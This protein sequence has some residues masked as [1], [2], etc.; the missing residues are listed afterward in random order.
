MFS[1]GATFAENCD[2]LDWFEGRR[3]RESRDRSRRI[4]RPS[5]H[6]RPSSPAGGSSRALRGRAFLERA[7]A[8]RAL[9]AAYVS[10]QNSALLYSLLDAQRFE[11]KRVELIR[12]ARPRAGERTGP[13]GM[14]GTI[15]FDSRGRRRKIQGRAARSLSAGD[16]R[17]SQAFAW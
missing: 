3:R 1:L 16:E 15:F 7:Q 2:R 17:S 10:M 11:T 9:L 5:L 12:S 13:F 4:E 8:G 14:S 6:A